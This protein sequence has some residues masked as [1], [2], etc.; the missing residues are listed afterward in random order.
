MITSLYNLAS[1]TSWLHDMAHQLY[2]NITLVLEMQD[3]NISPFLRINS[4]SMIV[5]SNLVNK[6]TALSPTSS[7]YF[8]RCV[9]WISCHSTIHPLHSWPF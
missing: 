9:I 8:L 4:L 7:P 1:T 2:T 3:W 5:L 6:S